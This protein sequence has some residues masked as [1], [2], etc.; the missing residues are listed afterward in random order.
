MIGVPLGYESNSVDEGGFFIDLVGLTKTK[1]LNFT[2]FS[3]LN[4]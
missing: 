1:S 2:G 4:P 3:E